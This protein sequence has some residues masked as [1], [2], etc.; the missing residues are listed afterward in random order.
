M[1][2]GGRKSDYR[3][4]MSTTADKPVLLG[5][6]GAPH[7][8]RGQVRIKSFTA[9]PLALGDYGALFDAKGATFEI[10]DLRQAKGVV[11]ATLKGVTTREAAEAL[12]GTELFVARDQLPDEILDQDEF[13]IEDLVGLTTADETGALTGTV[14]AVHNYGAGDMIE[15]RLQSGGQ[16]TLYPF[17]RAVV[18]DVDLAAG[19]L[20]LVPPGE[21]I[22]QPGAEDE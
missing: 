20:T 7:G 8:V 12:G 4:P 6:I 15:V 10:A 9:D 1:L 14:V 22:V 5:V 13:F 19:R 18:P 21:I 11:V 2:G 3:D 16:T 17:T